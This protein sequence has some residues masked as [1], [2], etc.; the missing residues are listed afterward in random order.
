MGG[1]EILVSAISSVASSVIIKGI[2]LPVRLRLAPYAGVGLVLINIVPQV[3]DIVDRI[4]S[5][6]VAICVEKTFGYLQRGS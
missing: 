6:R 4:L 2:D 3:K 5:N 1:K